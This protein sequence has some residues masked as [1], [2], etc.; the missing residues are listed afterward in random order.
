MRKHS[1]AL[2]ALVI[3]VAII[4]VTAFI[5]RQ[6]AAGNQRYDLRTDHLPEDRP[7]S[8]EYEEI[9][10]GDDHE[11]PRPVQ[12][13][14]DTARSSPMDSVRRK[15]LHDRQLLW[16][17]KSAGPMDWRETALDTVLRAKKVKQ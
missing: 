16:S 8:T 3:G 13:T 17:S 12:Q 14:T 2:R 10:I 7:G 6:Q 5:L 1:L 4:L 15:V 11:R 9:A